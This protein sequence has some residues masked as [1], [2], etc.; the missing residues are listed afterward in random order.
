MDFT[1]YRPYNICIC[2]MVPEKVITDAIDG[3]ADSFKKIQEAT[4]AGTGCGTCEDR[5]LK[6]LQKKKEEKR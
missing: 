2:H 3:G 5:I 1:A 4:H 6:I